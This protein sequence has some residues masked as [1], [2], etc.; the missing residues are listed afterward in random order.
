MTPYKVLQGKKPTLEH[1]KVFG[2]VAHAKIPTNK[3][4]N[5]GDRSERMMYLGNKEGSKA[6]RLY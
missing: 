6:F 3:V 2:Y 1:F 4:P 5:L